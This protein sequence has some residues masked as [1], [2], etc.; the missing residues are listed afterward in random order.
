M[1]NIKFLSVLLLLLLTFTGYGQVRPI[2]N[3]EKFTY[4]ET[5]NGSE[6]YDAGLTFDFEYPNS[7][8]TPE[9]ELEEFIKSS[10]MGIKPVKDGNAKIYKDCWLRMGLEYTP[11]TVVDDFGSLYWHAKEIVKNNPKFVDM[12]YYYLYSY[13]IKIENKII[14]IR[15]TGFKG[16]GWVA[17]N[18]TLQEWV[19]II[20]VF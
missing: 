16:L 1:K 6:Y 19:E 18:V 14:Q 7:W 20:Y 11:E 17:Y 2:P 13:D 12:R 3:Q 10:T 5:V 4:S 15:C 9:V 8:M